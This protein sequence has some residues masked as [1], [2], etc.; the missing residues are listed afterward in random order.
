MPDTDPFDLERF[1]TA[2]SPDFARALAELRAGRKQSHWMWYVFPQ[3]RGLGASAMSQRYGTS[4]LAE[5]RAYLA[6]QILGPRLHQCVE[7]LLGIEGRSARQILGHPD[8][9]KLQSSATLFAYASAPGSVFE[10]LLTKYFDGVPD[11][12]TLEMAISR[13][14]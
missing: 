11:P 12:A 13:R 4:G 6:H 5:A 7:V 3:L 9:R 1:V 10:Q 2:Q 8:D 14:L